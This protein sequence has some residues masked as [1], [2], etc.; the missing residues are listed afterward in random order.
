L[1]TWYESTDGEVASASL[2]LTELAPELD[3]GKPLPNGMTQLLLRAEKGA[4]KYSWP[5]LTACLARSLDVQDTIASI[6]RILEE[7]LQ[8]EMG[9]P[10]P[11]QAAYPD[12]DL[13]CPERI[14]CSG[15]GVQRW[16]AIHRKWLKK[17]EE[18]EAVSDV[19][20]LLEDPSSTYPRRSCS[21][22]RAF[23]DAISTNISVWIHKL[24][25]K[26]LYTLA[27]HG[28]SL[29]G[30]DGTNAK[31]REVRN[32]KLLLNR[33]GDGQ[34]RQIRMVHPPINSGLPHS[35]NF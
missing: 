17:E 1:K 2:L 16:R 7:L 22:I 3:R 19:A 32:E 20:T 25:K 18:Y 35:N 31:L 4:Q 26:G 23:Y 28:T 24:R 14:R 10:P 15:S 11:P 30:C 29:M 34:G 33:E 6:S 8:T 21:I 12:M 13:S 27:A 9:I 5:Q